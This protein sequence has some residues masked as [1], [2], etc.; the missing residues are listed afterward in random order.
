MYVKQD[1]RNGS[2]FNLCNQAR[3]ECVC[4]WVWIA[5][6]I[7]DGQ[8]V[9]MT[10]FSWLNHLWRDD[11]AEVYQTGDGSSVCR[12]MAEVVVGGFCEGT[13]LGSSEFAQGCC[14]L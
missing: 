12:S 8:I 11:E 6:L 7:R 10:R 9:G 2:A 3:R 5:G 4:G 1:E 13:V 14:R